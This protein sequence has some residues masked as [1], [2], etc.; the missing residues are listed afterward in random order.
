MTKRSV[1]LKGESFNDYLTAR[2][3]SGLDHSRF[4]WQ[5]MKENG[6]THEL[7][8]QYQQHLKTCGFIPGGPREKKTSVADDIGSGFKSR[9]LDDAALAARYHDKAT[10][11]PDL[12]D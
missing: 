5:R 8:T 7:E 9:L 4:D 10:Q 12:E 6:M 2:N 11:Q 3:Q 1:F